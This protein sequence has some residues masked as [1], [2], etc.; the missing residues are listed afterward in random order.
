MSEELPKLIAALETVDTA[1]ELCAIAEER[2]TA[3]AHKA[4]I[5]LTHERILAV[6]AKL[7]PA[8][9]APPSASLESLT[10]QRAARWPMASRQGGRPSVLIRARGIEARAK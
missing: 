2:P 10:R 5:G 9:S 7:G 6:V 1:V 3:E 4:R 8:A